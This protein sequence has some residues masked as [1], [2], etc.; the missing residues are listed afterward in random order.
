LASILVPAIDLVAIVV[1]AL[2]GLD[3]IAL[4]VSARHRAVRRAAFER[5][6]RHEAE[7][8]RAEVTRRQPVAASDGRL[9]PPITKTDCP[10]VAAGEAVDVGT[11]G[12][13]VEAPA[14]RV[15]RELAEGGVPWVPVP[16]PPPTYTLKPMAPRPEPAPLDL[17]SVPHPPDPDPLTEQQ[18]EPTEGDTRPP[19]PWEADR[20]F[21][22]DLDL[23]AVLARRRAVNG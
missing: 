6:R 3:L 14:E 20:T 16:V 4:V 1:T 2:L 5:A 7:R 17:P 19:W 22:D 8:R 23:D 15:A 18:A 10:A 12:S 13:G 9:A 21:A 11:R